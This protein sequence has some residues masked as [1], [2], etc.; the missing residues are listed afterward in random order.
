MVG[1][2]IDWRRG[3]FEVVAPGAESFV[4][5]EEFL[6][7]DIVVQLR[8]SERTGMER[9][10]VD[11]VLEVYREDGFEGVVGSV[12]L[13]DDR[14]VR[15]PLRKGRSG[16]EGFLQRVKR[17]LALFSPQSRSTLPSNPGERN[18]NVGIER[19]ETPIKVGEA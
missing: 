4:D 10:R 14:N 1:N 6:V 18:G 12:G 16:G 17:C 9:D 8:R 19:N 7:V 15:N 3:T 11:A 2:D 5:G 13:N